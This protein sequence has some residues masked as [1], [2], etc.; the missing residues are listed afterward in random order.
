MRFDLERI[1]SFDR[2]AKSEP[3]QILES[4]A[5][6]RLV[7]RILGSSTPMWQAPIVWLA[8][9]RLRHRSRWN[10]RV[11]KL[12]IKKNCNWNMQHVLAG[13]DRGVA[14]I[15]AHPTRKLALSGARAL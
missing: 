13:D 14:S 11:G 12:V 7:L 1:K 3:Q 15:S 8:L 5:A 9:G 6:W 4:H 10:Y 2:R